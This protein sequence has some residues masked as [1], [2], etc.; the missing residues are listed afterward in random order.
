MSS[1]NSVHFGRF[2][3]V[4]FTHDCLRI[5]FCVYQIFTFHDFP[6]N[7]RARFSH[8]AQSKPMSIE[9]H[10]TRCARTVGMAPSLFTYAESERAFNDRPTK[11][12][13][14][15]NQMCHVFICSIRRWTDRGYANNRNWNI[16]L[17]KYFDYVYIYILISF[18]SLLCFSSVPLSSV[19]LLWNKIWVVCVSNVK[20]V[21]MINDH[22]FFVNR[23]SS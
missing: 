8:H 20:V 14:N 18:S 6:H 15:R 23:I 5:L 17:W 21:T 19:V 9:L 2:P 12:T 4:L 10:N 16:K 1:Q 11:N 7:F 22:D 3:W 13:A